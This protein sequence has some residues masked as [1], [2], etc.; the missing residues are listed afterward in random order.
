MECK[1][2]LAFLL[3]NTSILL[4]NPK[5]I[6]N[7]YINKIAHIETTKCN[8][9]S[10]HKALETIHRM[11]ELL[12][13]SNLEELEKEYTR[14]FVSNYPRLPCPLYESA[15]VGKDRFLAEPTVINDINH[16]LSKLNLELNKDLY[17]FP[18]SLPVELELAHIL[19]ALEPEDPENITPLINL[20]LIKHLSK[21]LPIIS[22]CIWH[23]TSNPYYRSLS[24]LLAGIAD[25]ISDIY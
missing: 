3:K 4:I 5:T 16:I 18:D 2:T 15:Y 25:C 13:E 8:L 9:D 1:E 14:L 6:H 19:V 11:L 22:R 17:R 21:W 23:N 12:R 20:L 7:N 24:R 10:C